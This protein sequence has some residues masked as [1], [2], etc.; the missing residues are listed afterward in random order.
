MHYHPLKPGTK[1]PWQA[2]RYIGSYRTQATYANPKDALDAIV[3]HCG[4]N[5]E[6]VYPPLVLATSPAEPE[7]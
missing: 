4:E 3:K 2:A 6:Q 1:R 7:G 5:P